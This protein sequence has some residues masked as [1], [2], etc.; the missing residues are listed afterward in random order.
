MKTHWP[1]YIDWTCHKKGE[2]SVSYE[3]F[4][5]P[6]LQI[7]F[8]EDAGTWKATFRKAYTSGKWSDELDVEAVLEQMLEWAETLDS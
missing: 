8:D 7:T 4:E 1:L 6:D 3:S 2:A 5:F